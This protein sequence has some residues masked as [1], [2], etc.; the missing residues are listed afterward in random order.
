[1]LKYFR[2]KQGSALPKVLR[3]SKHAMKKQTRD[4]NG[5]EHNLKDNIHKATAL[6]T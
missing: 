1:M 3:Q 2:N 5:H 4:T 6:D